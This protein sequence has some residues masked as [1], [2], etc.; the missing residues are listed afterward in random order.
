[1]T[2]EEENHL[3]DGHSA[4][5]GDDNLVAPALFSLRLVWCSGSRIGKQLPGGPQLC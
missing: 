2:G 1:M 3:S 5:A 4:K